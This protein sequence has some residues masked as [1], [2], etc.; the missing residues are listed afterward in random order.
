[1]KKAKMRKKDKELKTFNLSALQKTLAA[2]KLDQFFKLLKPVVK[3]YGMSSLSQDAKIDR[4]QL[5]E[6]FVYQKAHP[7]LDTLLPILRC[8]GLVLSVEKKAKKKK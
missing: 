4:S 6:I 7:R 1:M 8:L 2:G 3:D 5:Y